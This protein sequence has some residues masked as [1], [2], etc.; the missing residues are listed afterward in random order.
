MAEAL[1]GYGIPEIFNTDQGNQFTSIA[2]TGVLEATGIRC[3]MDGC[4][5]GSVGAAGG[6]EMT[7]GG[8]GESLVP[9]GATRIEGPAVGP[10][11]P[12]A[13]R[14]GRWTLR[15]AW[16]ASWW[17]VGEG[18]KSLPWGAADSAGGLRAGLGGL[19]GATENDN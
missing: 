19:C 14:L 13:A 11:P 1:A 17:A 5:R 16:A 7:G 6:R 9:N 2:F 3:S 8:C 4:G 18:W 10:G 12:G 15:S